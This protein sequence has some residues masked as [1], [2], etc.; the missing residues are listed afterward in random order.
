MCIIYRMIR[1]DRSPTS[2]GGRQL[3]FGGASEREE[4]YTYKNPIFFLP[5]VVSH[6]HTHT[7]TREKNDTPRV[8]IKK[9][10]ENGN[11]EI[12]FVLFYV[13]LDNIHTYYYASR[14]ETG[15]YGGE[16]KK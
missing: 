7:D 10:T 8:V 9:K 13:P 6:T 16:K 3:P 15:T 14:Q 1:C 4:K 12:M 5:Y 11:N 2:E